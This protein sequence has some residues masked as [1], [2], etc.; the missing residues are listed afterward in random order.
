M[1]PRSLKTDEMALY[2]LENFEWCTRE[3]SFPSSPLPYDYRDL[4]PNFNVAAV[5]EASRDFF[6]LEISQPVFRM[7]LL[8]NAMKLGVLC[9]WMINI[10]ESTL[11]ELWWSTFM[12]WVQHNRNNILQARHPETVPRRRV[13]GLAMH[14]PFLVM[15]TK[16]RV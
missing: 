8:N 1:F 3:L 12:E 11:K 6:L 15:A 16:S 10:T 13:Q 7:M 2:V 5:D 14:P 4:C 9:G